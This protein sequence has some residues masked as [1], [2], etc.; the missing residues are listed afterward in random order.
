M[1]YQKQ[2]SLA[3]LICLPSSV[4]A[5]DSTGSCSNCCM[6]TSF[7]EY[8]PAIIDVPCAILASFAVYIWYKYFE[9]DYIKKKRVDFDESFQYSGTIP[10]AGVFDYKMNVLDENKWIQKANC[11]I[12][13][14]DSII[15]EIEGL[16]YKGIPKKF[17]TRIT[18]SSKM[19]IH[20]CHN[21]LESN[22][23]I[24]Y[25]TRVP[26]S[27]K[28]GFVAVDSKIYQEIFVLLPNECQTEI[29]ILFPLM[30]SNF[31]KLCLF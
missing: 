26:G 12:Q 2:F 18:D 8:L 22:D 9:A 19:H 20:F 31:L 24:F 7:I 1:N 10:F 25:L 14:I 11:R 29:S 3:I 17:D 5:F 28:P 16:D 27:D 23:F 30:K 6:P 21:P 4:S 15:V 13:F